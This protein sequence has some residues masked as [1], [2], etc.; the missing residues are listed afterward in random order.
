VG[1]PEITK[2]AMALSATTLRGIEVYLAVCILYFLIY[3]LFLIAV[4]QVERHF[5][6]PGMAAI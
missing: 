1:I 6:V 3:R 5:R 2:Q 4:N